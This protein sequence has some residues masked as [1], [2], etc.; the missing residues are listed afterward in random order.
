MEQRNRNPYANVDWE[1]CL[2][3]TG[4]THVHCTEMK[5][6]ER[7]LRTG[8]DFLTLSNYYPSAPYWPLAKMTRNYY[9][10]HHE[11][12]L[13]MGHNAMTDLYSPVVDGKFVP[14]PFDWNKILDGWKDE[15]EEEYRS[16]LPFV[17]LM[18]LAVVTIW[19]M[20]RGTEIEPDVIIPMTNQ[21]IEWTG[22]GYGG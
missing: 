1:N 18:A 16:K 3:L 9:R 20:L 13:M 17:E 7:L 8:I 6:Y 4:D 5:H 12:G 21:H 2:R 19:E 15:I 14:G 10:C 11:H 22:A